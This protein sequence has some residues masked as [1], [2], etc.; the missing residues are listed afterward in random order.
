METNLLSGP[1]LPRLARFALPILLANLLQTCYSM[2]DMAVVG[3]FVG[4]EGLAGVSSAAMVSYIIQS[5]CTGLTQGGGVLAA[6]CRGAG[7][8]AALRRAVGGLFSLSALAAALLTLAGCL[9]CRPALSAMGLS[10]PALAHGA[11]YLF[12][13][14][15]GTVF[16]FGY[17]AVCALLRGLGD[18]KSPLYFVAL[19][20]VV[21]VALDL[22][23]VDRLGTAGAAIATVLSQ[24]LSFL[25][26]LLWL[27]RRSDVPLSFRFYR[28]EWLDILRTG[29]PAAVQTAVLNLSYLLVTGMFNSCGVVVAAAAGVGLKLNSCAALPCWAVGSAVTAMAGQCVGAGALRRAAWVCRAGVILSMA[30]TLAAMLL[31]Q[32]FTAPL[33]GFFDPDPAVVAEG[34]R[35]LR[36]CCSLNCLFY[37]AMYAYDSFATGTGAAGLAMINSLV[38]S[39]AVRLALSLLLSARMG[40]LGLYLAEALAPIPSALLGF[41][42]FHSGMWRRFLPPAENR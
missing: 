26:A 28:R 37:A 23:L 16:V 29:L 18:S 42:F 21:N 39:V 41:L 12:P 19:A 9:L 22:L 8:G 32:L 6:R 2:A 30:V 13:L 35:Y 31:V 34:V 1:V 24:G 27:R 5:V 7:D 25:A 3:R 15:L 14:C 17:N 38:Q 36:I 20:T 33:V 10:G 40:A 11:G 4:S